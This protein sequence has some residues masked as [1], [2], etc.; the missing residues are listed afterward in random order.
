MIDDDS[1][2]EPSTPPGRGG[3]GERD[4]ARG[5]AGTGIGGG[6]RPAA[7]SSYPESVL[8]L[9]DELAKLPGIGR[10]SAERLAFHILKTPSERALLLATAI[11]DVKQRVRHCAVCYNLADQREAHEDVHAASAQ[12]AGHLCAICRDTERDRATVM[13]VEQPKDLIA[14]EQTGAYRGLYHVLMGRISPLDGVGP[15]DVTID[16]LLHRVRDPKANAG[17]VAVAEV[18]LALNPT[19]ESDGTALYLMQELGRVGGVGGAGGVGGGKGRAGP[20]VTRIARGVPT[21][22]NLE[23]ASKA[24]LAD[25]IEGRRPMED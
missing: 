13:V 16:D 19:M 6:V 2:S 8:R 14:L 4:H 1:I 20:R 17:G 9:I 3:R 25:A 21:G 24:V 22:A 15:G 5:A 11:R 10:R 7:R 23:Y 12:G 18:V